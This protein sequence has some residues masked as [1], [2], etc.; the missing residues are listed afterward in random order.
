M[1]EKN[2]IT[3]MVQSKQIPLGI[4]VF[5]GHP[6]LIEIIGL[7]G[8][9]FIMLDTEHSPNDARQLEGLIRVADGV[10]LVT[11]VRVS[12]H[13]D[14]G[15][16]HRALEAGAQGILLPLIRTADDVKRAAEA[17]YFPMKGKRGVSPSVRAARYDAKHYDE[18]VVW[19]N[20]EILLIPMI[21]RAEALDNVEAICALDEV[22]MIVF[23]PSDLGYSLGEGHKMMDSPVVQEAFRK[24]LDA[25]KRHDV[26]VFGGPMYNPTPE[27]CRK[28]LDAG[29]SIFCLGV[30]T[31]NFRQICENTVRVVNACVEGSGFSRPTAPPSGLKS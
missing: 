25:A 3:T 29:V 20:E 15:D 24:V 5:T 17:A 19:T 28:A 11:F 7:T 14:D 8:Y 2:R 16:I 18:Y 13:D 21:E 4:Q 31:L 30:D 26:A 22:K 12:R 27:A 6:A 23:A 1:Y 9:D 10:G